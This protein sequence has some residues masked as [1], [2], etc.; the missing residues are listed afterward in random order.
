YC[1]SR[2]LCRKAQ[3]RHR[4]FKCLSVGSREIQEYL[5]DP[6][7]GD[8]RREISADRRESHD[9]WIGRL[10]EV[11]QI[12]PLVGQLVTEAIWPVRADLGAQTL[13]YAASVFE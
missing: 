11:M 5:L 4:H 10:L 8:I 1:A 2:P 6:Q 12:I 3:R 9:H 7:V 13:N